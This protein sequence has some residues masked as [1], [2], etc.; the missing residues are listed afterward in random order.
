MN[1]TVITR[2]LRSAVDSLQK[3]PG[4]VSRQVPHP[5]AVL[6]DV[7]SVEPLVFGRQKMRFWRRLLSTVRWWLAKLVSQIRQRIWTSGPVLSIDLVDLSEV[8]PLI[9]DPDKVDWVRH[10]EVLAR[11]ES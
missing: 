1:K 7:A 6:V 11:L 2:F 10:P 4:I 5:G 9:F 3:V 8:T